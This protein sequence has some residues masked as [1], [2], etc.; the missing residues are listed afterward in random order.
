MVRQANKRTVEHSDTVMTASD[1]ADFL[2]VS[3]AA[4]RRWTRN[5]VL[6]GRRLGGTG[7][8]RYFKEDVMDF[9]TREE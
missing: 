7:D 4:V 6:R 2:K 5:G 9:L 1:V 3:V 8:W